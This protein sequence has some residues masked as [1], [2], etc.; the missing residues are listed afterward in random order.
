MLKKPHKKMHIIL[1]SSIII[2]FSGSFNLVSAQISSEEPLRISV[3]VWAPNFLAY[4]AQEKGYFEKNNVDV[5]ITLVQDY[6]ATLRDYV[7]GEYD[8]MFVVYSDAL[9]QDSEGIDTKVVFNT[10]ISNGADPIIGKV[11]N[12]TE[13]KGKKVGV[14][15]INSFSHY[16]LLESLEKVGLGEGDVEFVNMPAQNISDALK[17]SE[18]DRR[19]HL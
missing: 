6:A 12:L 15:G 16:Y 19:S 11:D 2:L 18:I 4:V 10:D 8:G 9:L 1:V 13:L 17:K 5:N 7:D 3:G 14:D